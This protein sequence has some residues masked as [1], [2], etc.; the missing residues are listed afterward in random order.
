VTHDIKTIDSAGDSAVV[1]VNLVDHVKV[2]IVSLS[3]TNVFVLG[4]MIGVLSCNLKE[5]TLE[6]RFQ[7]AR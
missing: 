1:V 3:E 5:N 6:G 7:I 2:A 4:V